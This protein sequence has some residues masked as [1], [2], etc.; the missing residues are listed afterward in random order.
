MA[1]IRVLSGW[2]VVSFVV[3]HVLA[4][5]TRSGLRG[6][7]ASIARA[8][9]SLMLSIVPSC[10]AVCWSLPRMVRPPAGEPA[11]GDGFPRAFRLNGNGSGRNRS[12]GM[13]FAGRSL[14]VPHGLPLTGCLGCLCAHWPLDFCTPPQSQRTSGAPPSSRNP[15]TPGARGFKPKVRGSWLCA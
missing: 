4:Q 3:M 6:R 10:P 14:L 15:L 9:Q 2:S 7:P 12:L 13:S 8:M 11:C 5:T 1:L